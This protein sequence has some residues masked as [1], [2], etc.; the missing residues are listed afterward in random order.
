MPA[1]IGAAYAVKPEYPAASNTQFFFNSEGAREAYMQQRLSHQPVVGIIPSEI[2]FMVRMQNDGAFYRLE[3]LTS[4]PVAAR[5]IG[6]KLIPGSTAEPL[7]VRPFL[8]IYA[9]RGFAIEPL[10]FTMNALL[11]MRARKTRPAVVS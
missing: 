7:P 6:E 5:R 3:V 2:L 4:N 11:K 10:A 8:P 9:A 1:G